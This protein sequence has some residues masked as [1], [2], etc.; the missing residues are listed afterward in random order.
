M[1]QMARKQQSYTRNYGYPQAYS[2][3]DVP[4]RTVPVRPKKRIQNAIQPK[5]RKKVNPFARIISL[6]LLACIGY[7]IIP[8]AFHD[9][10]LPLLKGKHNYSNVKADYY[11][12]LFPTTNYL[13]NTIFNNRR[14]FAKA[15]TKKPLMTPIYKTEE[16]TMLEG[17]LRELMKKYPSIKP[18]ITVWDFNTGKYADI[19][20]SEIYPAASIIKVPVLISLF[21]SIEANRLSIYDEM[22]LTHYYK[23]SGSG[24]L[25][26]HATG[27][28]LTIDNL[29]KVMIEE[30]DNSATNML[31]SKLGSMTAVNSD[32]RSWGIKNT[33]VQTWLPDL[34]GTNYTTTNDMATMLFNLDNPSFL[35]INSREYIVDYMSH[36]KND[37]LI[38][39]G[40]GA[41]ATFLHK[42]G[43][44]GSMLGD[45][46]IV[47]MPDGRKYIVVIM[48]NRPYNS[49]QGKL[50]IQQASKI[51]Y[52]YM[53]TLY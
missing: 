52:N 34:K 15:K 4:V 20:G 32:I 31:M 5:K 9:I 53:A 11:N 48:A 8:K 7:F 44:I 25:Q 18:A 50:F 37:R 28:K 39:Q 17:S 43:D 13:S 36:V 21:K 29:A 10:S 23:A 33:H 49:P 35:S 40:L 47:F 1:P 3:A 46:G 30:S 16:L 12:I 24:S 6:A 27:K 19:N 51:I 14:A 38:P 45:A 42:T 2:Y 41:G 22:Y 26:Y